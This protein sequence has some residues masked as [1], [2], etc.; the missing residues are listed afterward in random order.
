MSQPCPIASLSF[1]VYMGLRV[2]HR[3]ESQSFVTPAQVGVQI[4]RTGWI[5]AF[6]GMT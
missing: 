5:P 3:N 6:A 2:T 4:N 1:R